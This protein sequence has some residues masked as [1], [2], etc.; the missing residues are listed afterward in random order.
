MQRNNVSSSN[1]SSIGYD[2]ASETLEIEFLNSSIYQYYGVPSFLYE[3]LMK[4]SSKGQFFNAYIRNAF[5]FSR[6]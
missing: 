1:I 4:E 2:A 6:V 5:P 3:N